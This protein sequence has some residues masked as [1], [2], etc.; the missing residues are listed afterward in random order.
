MSETAQ[1]VPAKEAFID[2]VAVAAR[3]AAGGRRTA[4]AASVLDIVGLAHRAL[5]LEEL[6]GSTFELLAAFDRMPRDAAAALIADQALI[7]T[8]AETLRAL[9]YHQE[10]NGNVEEA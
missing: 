10:T 3:I 4:I 1:Q 7:T 5:K 9:G 8:I 2:P 6:A